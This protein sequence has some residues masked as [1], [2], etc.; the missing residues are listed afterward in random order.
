MK[1]GCVV[2][3][4]TSPDYPGEIH[5]LDLDED[6][7]ELSAPEFAE[8]ANTTVAKFGWQLLKANGKDK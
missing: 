8:H 5:I 2:G 4:D 3:V 1:G 6:H 7:P